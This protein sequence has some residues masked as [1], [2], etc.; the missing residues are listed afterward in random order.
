MREQ[1]TVSDLIL[2]LADNSMAVFAL[3][4]IILLVHWLYD[5]AL[6]G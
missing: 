6:G 5:V 2:W 3:A 4:V 1:A